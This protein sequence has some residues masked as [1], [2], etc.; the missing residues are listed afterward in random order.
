MEFKSNGNEL[1]RKIP[2]FNKRLIAAMQRGLVEGLRKFESE[3]IVR[4]QLT[5]RKS[6]NY[7]LNR[8]TG[9]AA[10]QHWTLKKYLTGLDFTAILQMPKNAWY[11]KIHQHYNFDG[12]I[13]P[14]NKKYLTVPISKRAQGRSAADFPEMF[15]IRSKAGTPLLVRKKSKNKLELMYALK[16]RVHI[17]KRLY[18]TE[19]FRTYG[20]RFM[21]DRIN[22]RAREEIGK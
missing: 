3:R 4:A 2:E 15:L 18:I 22:A 21:H 12:T 7:G 16:K 10:V 9:G 8:H 11:L 14:K 13:K 1:A 20:R 5:G 17:P 6:A 19:E